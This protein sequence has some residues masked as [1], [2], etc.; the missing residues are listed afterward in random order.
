MPE[1]PPAA[2]LSRQPLQ[3]ASTP[4]Q[5]GRTAR[6]SR[7]AAHLP[8]LGTILYWPS[9]AASGRMSRAIA[10]I[11]GIAWSHI[12]DCSYFGNAQPKLMVTALLATCDRRYLSPLRNLDPFHLTWEKEQGRAALEASTHL[13]FHGVLYTKPL[14]S[15]FV[16]ALLVPACTSTQWV[17]TVGNPEIM[18]VGRTQQELRHLA[19]LKLMALLPFPLHSSWEEAV[20]DHLVK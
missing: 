11:H 6:N 4:G 9:D 12:S 18:V 16:E 14:G 10:V 20:M 5:R 1:L 15:G 17:Q 3:A 7:E 2:Q 13:T 8:N 19:Y